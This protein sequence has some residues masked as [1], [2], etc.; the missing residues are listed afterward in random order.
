MRFFTL[1]MMSL[2]LAA[3]AAAPVAT[4]SV[5]LTALP[6]ASPTPPPP[7]ATPLPSVES[8]PDAPLTLVIWWP[9]PLNP[10]NDSEAN[11]QLQAQ[12]DAFEAANPDVRV[13]WRRKL[14]SEVGGI[15]SGLRTASAAAPGALP[16]LT[17]LRRDDLLLAAQ[18]GL[19]Q[20]LQGRVSSAILGDLYPAPL[21]LGEVDDTLF[22]LTYMLEVQHAIYR[23]PLALNG[24]SYADV[25]ARDVPFVFPAARPNGVNDVFLAQYLAALRPDEA[26]QIGSGTLPLNENAL[27]ST[28]AFYEQARVNNIITPAVLDMSAPIDFVAYLGESVVIVPASTY[29]TLTG[30]GEDLLYAPIP[31]AAGANITMLDGWMWVLVTSSADRQQRALDFIT[32]MMDAERH[33]AFSAAVHRVPAQRS[34]LRL[35]HDD[36]YGEFISALVENAFL[37]LPESAATSARVLQNALSAVLLGQR[38]ADEATQDV[39]TQLAG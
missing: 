30:H 4:Q 1:S 31:N 34:T 20:A 3:C 7:E 16:D 33:A 12:I 22:G 13:N 23:P 37:P 26:A 39:L 14:V 8:Q 19:L 9:E 5:A 2:L 21:R 10:V 27:R 35:W 38:T 36:A 6:T 28:L 32:W 18:L 17:L 25:L 24:W 11:S 29:L 15:M